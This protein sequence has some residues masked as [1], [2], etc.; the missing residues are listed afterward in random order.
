MNNK[1]KKKLAIYLAGRMDYENDAGHKWRADL[2]PFL[3]GMGFE[4]LNPYEFEPEQLKG[5]KRGRLP[6]GMKHW[7]ELRDSP[8]PN[9]RQRFMKYMRRIIKYDL[10][11][12][13]NVVD[14]IIVFWDEGCKT[15]AGTHAE[16][17]IAWDLGKPIYCVEAARMPSWAK[18]CCEELFKSFDE[19]RA[20]MKNEFGDGQDDENEQLDFSDTKAQ[21]E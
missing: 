4:V 5:L 17:T 11:L 14:Y 20:F 18:A 3:E 2:T 7:T 10:N 9:H 1:V 19:L 6:E 13:R 21:E 15:G 16:L 8:D 12:I